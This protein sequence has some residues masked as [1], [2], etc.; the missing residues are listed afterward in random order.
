[1]ETNEIELKVLQIMNGFFIAIILSLI[2]VQSV[3]GKPLIELSKLYEPSTQWLGISWDKWAIDNDSTLIFCGHVDPNSKA[4]TY[5]GEH[6]ASLNNG[7]SLSAENK[8]NDFG[9]NIDMS[10]I[11][12]LGIDLLDSDHYL[13]DMLKANIVAGAS[14]IMRA[15]KLTDKLLDNGFSI[16]IMVDGYSIGMKSPL[17][18]TNSP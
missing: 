4:I 3:Y 6:T 5:L 17:I 11:N 2:T 12:P 13:W 7:Y 10:G 15:Y 18:I 14:N 16:K 1:M 9:A 8:Y